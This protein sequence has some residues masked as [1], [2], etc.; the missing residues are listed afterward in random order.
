LGLI[1]MRCGVG[2]ASKRAGEAAA[3]E[4]NTIPTG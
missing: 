3:R 2:G 1:G 4:I